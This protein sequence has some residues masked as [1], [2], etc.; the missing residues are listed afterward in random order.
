MRRVRH[1][2]IDD[3]V[4]SFPLSMLIDECKSYERSCGRDS[5]LV[6]EWPEADLLKFARGRLSRS[7]FG[8]QDC[9][10]GYVKD[11]SFPESWKYERYDNDETA[12]ARSPF[13]SYEDSSYR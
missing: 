1:I 8:S 9:R 7:F 11:Y 10:L 3:T 4:Y 12:W 5:R 2:G 13:I 6:D